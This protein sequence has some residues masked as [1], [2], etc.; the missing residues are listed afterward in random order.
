MAYYREKLRYYR[1]HFSYMRMTSKCRKDR[2]GFMLIMDYSE[3]LNKMRSQQ[4]QS[5]H[6]DT[7]A[8]TIEVAVAEGYKPD[9][10]SMS[11]GWPRS[12]RS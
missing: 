11:R 8:M 10:S 9:R 6:W 5:Q 7:T 12:S 4:V 3:K 2:S 1:Y